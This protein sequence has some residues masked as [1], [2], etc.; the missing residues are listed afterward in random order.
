VRYHVKL[1]D[2]PTLALRQVVFDLLE[3]FNQSKAGPELEVPLALLIH[4]DDEGAVIGGLWGLTYY[5]WLFVELLFVPE[6]LRGQGLGRQ[7]LQ[8]AEAEAVRRGCH[9]AWLETFT[10]QAPEFY[11]KLGYQ[12]FGI[13]PNY[14]AGHGRV[15]MCKRIGPPQSQTAASAPS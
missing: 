2:Q 15:F 10:F 12:P 5:G 3:A 4:D 1:E 7:L 8:E 14:P 6:F 9:G 13:V 11:R